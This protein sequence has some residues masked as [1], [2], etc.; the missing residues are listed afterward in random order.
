[1]IDARL[2]VVVGKGSAATTWVVVDDI[3]EVDIPDTVQYFKHIGIKG[4]DF[5]DKTVKGP[6]ARKNRINFL[7]FLIHLWPGDW[8]E[9]LTYL[10]SIIEEKQN[11]DVSGKKYVMRRISANEFWRFFGLMLAARLEGRTG[12]LWDTD[13]FRE[14]TGILKKVDYTPY[15]TRTRFNE[16]RQYMAF[17]FA[18]KSLSG[19]D[20]WWQIMGGLNGFNENR[21]RVVQAPNIKV[22]DE[23][24]SAFRPQTRK[25]GNLPSISFILRKPENLGTEL[26]DLAAGGEFGTF[27]K[28]LFYNRI[29]RRMPVLPRMPEEDGTLTL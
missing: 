2:A 14:T 16:I 15:M 28:L 29:P 24:M 13:R 27:E 19:K 10:N 20:D 4:F 25:F 6:D 12:T 7:Q 9:Q 22:L 3:K 8:K 17:V 5:S 18:D 1:M 21:R 11:R 23:T 26:K